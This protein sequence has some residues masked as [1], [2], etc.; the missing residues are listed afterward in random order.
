MLSE[1][2]QRHKHTGVLGNST[3]TGGCGNAC[4]GGEGVESLK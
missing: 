3:R 2:L 4:C 1:E